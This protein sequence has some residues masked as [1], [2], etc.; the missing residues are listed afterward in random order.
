MAVVVCELGN[1]ISNE[2]LGSLV[3]RGTQEHL[4]MGGMFLSDLFTNYQNIY[5]IVFAKNYGLTL[6]LANF[7]C[8]RQQGS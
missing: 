7:L 2:T 5:S 3:E 8:Q 4:R 1:I 6:V